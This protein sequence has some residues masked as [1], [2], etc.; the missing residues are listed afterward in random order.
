VVDDASYPEG[1]LW[2]GDDLFFAEMRRDRVMVWN[3]VEAA[4]WWRRPGCGPTAI[5]PYAAGDFIVLCHLSREI[6][7]VRANGAD[8]KTIATD[9]DGRP[10]QDPNDATSDGASGIFFSDSGVFST[11]AQATGAILHLDDSGAVRRLANGLHYANGVHFARGFLFVSEH[12][13]RRVLRYPVSR[14]PIVS[15]GVAQT[16]I[17]FPRSPVVDYPEAGP[18][19]LEFD[20]ANRL[21]VALY[22][23]GRLAAIDPDSG[24]IG[25]FKVSM[26]FVTT[27]AF[28]PSGELAVAGAISNDQQP[29]PGT[30]QIF[31]ASQLT[32]RLA[33]E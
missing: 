7:H 16:V 5:A 31:P 1:A 11:H 6:V 19:G 26:P 32:S 20:N 2:V 9:I 27:V 30:V 25:Y 24:R 3:G 18:D 15:L 13:G 33:F 8:V 21:W 22:G 28:G 14:A 17:E 12:L 29:Y 4:V 23:E 10:F